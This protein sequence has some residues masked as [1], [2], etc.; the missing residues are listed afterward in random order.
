[1]QVTRGY[2]WNRCCTCNW[3]TKN[4]KETGLYSRIKWFVLRGGT[5]ESH[6]ITS[7]PNDI[8]F[9]VISIVCCFKWLSK[10]IARLRL[11]R[12]VIGLTVRA[13]FST[14]EKQNQS[15]SHL[16]RMIFRALWGSAL[17]AGIVTGRSNFFGVDFSTVIWKPLSERG[18]PGKSL[19][20]FQLY[21]WRRR[22]NRPLRKIP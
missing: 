22:F 16:L 1:M 3:A 15:N 2:W 12:L 21:W 13:T 20:L 17:L 19:E 6:Y 8:I 7:S 10:A 18:I 9:S 5:G 11:L 4:F 14:N